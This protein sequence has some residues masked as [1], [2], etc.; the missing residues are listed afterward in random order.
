MGFFS[1]LF[2]EDESKIID[3]KEQYER[4]WN[5][6]R[7]YHGFEQNLSKAIYW[8]EKAAAQGNDDAMDSL[9][10]IYNQ[11]YKDYSKAFMWYKKASEAGNGLAQISLGDMFMEGKGLSEPDYKNAIYWLTK[12]SNNCDDL[13]KG[14]PESS[15]GLIYF[16]GLGMSKSNYKQAI[17]WF[18]RSIVHSYKWPVIIYSV[19]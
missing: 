9:G 17:Y 5:Y 14:D 11:Y 7:G 12:A 19:I 3:P 1:W 16:N 6:Y 4:G 8:F 18:E 15:L 10:L 13:F 2:G